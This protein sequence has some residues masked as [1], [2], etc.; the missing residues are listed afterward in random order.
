MYLIVI[1]LLILEHYQG[2]VED[3]EPMILKIKIKVTFTPNGSTLLA[4]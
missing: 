3:I 4:V 1:I 2:L